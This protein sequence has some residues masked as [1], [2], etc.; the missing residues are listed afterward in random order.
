MHS[1]HMCSHSQSIY[2][3]YRSYTG[4]YSDTHSPFTAHTVHI[5]ASRR[6]TV[7][8]QCVYSPC[9]PIQTH[10]QR[11]YKLTQSKYSPNSSYTAVYSSYTAVYTAVYSAYA[12]YTVHTQPIQ[13]TYTVHIQSIYSPYAAH[14]HSSIHSMC[15][16]GRSCRRRPCK[17]H[18]EPPRHPGPGAGRMSP[19]SF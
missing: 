16:R 8:I 14:A 19:R 2:S 6:H 4:V 7:Y 5:Q 10:I 11:M 13:S 17:L 12:A 1:E 18:P 9:R 3:P 15:G